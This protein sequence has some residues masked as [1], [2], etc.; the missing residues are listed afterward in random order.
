MNHIYVALFTSGWAYPE[1][2]DFR[3]C[4]GIARDS[5]VGLRVVVLLPCSVLSRR[6]AGLVAVWQNS[7]GRLSGI[8]RKQYT[9]HISRFRQIEISHQTVICR[10]LPCIQAVVIWF[11]QKEN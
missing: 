1:Y 9:E 5:L 8:A 10:V 3:H 7:W 6:F 4:C 2:P 11:R